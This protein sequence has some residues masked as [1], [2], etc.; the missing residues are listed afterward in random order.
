MNEG[1]VYLLF[2]TR[3]ISP[4]ALLSYCFNLERIFIL[5]TEKISFFSC[6]LLIDVMLCSRLKEDNFFWLLISSSPISITPLRRLRL[7][8]EWSERIVVILCKKDKLA[9]DLIGGLWTNTYCL[10][11]DLRFSFFSVWYTCF[12][13]C[14]FENLDNSAGFEAYNDF[15]ECYFE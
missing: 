8:K 14:F 6:S 15:R 3:L 4:N 5:F 9:A 10:S 7:Y 2:I 1:L 12:N 13:N 11:E